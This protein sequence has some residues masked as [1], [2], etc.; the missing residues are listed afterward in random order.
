M[1]SIYPVAVKLEGLKP[2]LNTFPV[3]KKTNGIDVLEIRI[4]ISLFVFWGSQML[5]ACMEEVCFYQKALKKEQFVNRRHLESNI[6]AGSKEGN[7]GGSFTDTFSS[8]A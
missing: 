3:I 2:F 6:C 4:K 1:F 8:T 5:Q 7:A